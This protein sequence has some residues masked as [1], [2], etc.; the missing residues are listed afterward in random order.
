[1]TVDTGYLAKLTLAE[2]AARDLGYLHTGRALAKLVSWEE[3]RIKGTLSKRRT[4]DHPLGIHPN[5][6]DETV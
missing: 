5:S 1:M 6:A 4:H 2:R 3:T